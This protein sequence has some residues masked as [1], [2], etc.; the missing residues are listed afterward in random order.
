MTCRRATPNPWVL[1]PV[2]FATALGAALGYLVTS[3]GCRPDSCTITAVLM[4]IAGGAVGGVGVGV[5]AVLALRSLEE[6][7]RS[8][9]PP[10]G[11]VPD[12]ESTA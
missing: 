4:A 12:D 5:V 2:L 1:I 11:G 9:T 6:W 7:H 3:I 10:D 8:G